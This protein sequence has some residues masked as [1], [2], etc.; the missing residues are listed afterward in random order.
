MFCGKLI[1]ATAAESI[2]LMQLMSEE[3]WGDMERWCGCVDEFGVSFLCDSEV[4][5][6]RCLC[7]VVVFNVVDIVG[8]VFF[9]F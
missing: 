5:G 2:A 7:R 1:R 8:N 3:A 4:D 6:V 9:F